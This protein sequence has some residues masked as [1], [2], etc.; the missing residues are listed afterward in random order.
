M[1]VFIPTPAFSIHPTIIIIYGD[2]SATIHSF[3]DSSWM[4]SIWPIF[5]CSLFRTWP[6]EKSHDWRIKKVCFMI[7]HVSKHFYCS[8]LVN[9]QPRPDYCLL[10]LFTSSPIG[11]TTA[12]TFRWK[13]FRL[14]C[15][16]FSDQ[17]IRYPTANNPPTFAVY[18]Q[19][20]FWKAEKLLFEKRYCEKD[21]VLLPPWLEELL[22]G[23]FRL[24]TEK[25]RN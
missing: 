21:S 18:I 4:R 19:E 2:L 20:R 22:S 12:A 5:V 24:V 23:L 14:C 7:N 13:S 9:S 10:I 25:Q 16:N 1:Y 3:I 17:T 6:I 11:R 15:V 8:H